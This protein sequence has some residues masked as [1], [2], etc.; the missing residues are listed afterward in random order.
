MPSNLV[1]TKVSPHSCDAHFVVRNWPPRPHRLLPPS[2]LHGLGSPLF[3]HGTLTVPVVHHCT[4]L[5]HLSATASTLVI[6]PECVLRSSL[7]S[8][9]NLAFESMHF[10][11][12]AFGT[13]FLADGFAVILWNFFLIVNPARRHIRAGSPFVL[14]CSFIKRAAMCR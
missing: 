14:L 3:L 11:V 13:V 9:E 1:K 12:H 6:R 2:Y 7:M 4:F 8:C 5:Y 10:Q